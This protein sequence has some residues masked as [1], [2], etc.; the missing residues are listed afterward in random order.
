MAG[1]RPVG[2]T[3]PKIMTDALILALNREAGDGQTKQLAM[4]AKRLVERAAEGDV[5]AIKEVFDRVDGKPHQ[6]VDLDTQIGGELTLR[7]QTAND[8][9]S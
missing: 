9:K 5:Q 6:S 1:G 2:S 4:I 7:W 8:E 3:K